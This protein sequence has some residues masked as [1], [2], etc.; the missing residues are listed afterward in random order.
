MDYYLDVK[1]Y[2]K[3]GTT[4]K[5][6]RKYASN[7]P[8]TDEKWTMNAIAEPR[9]HSKAALWSGRVLSGLVILFLTLDAAMKMAFVSQVEEASAQLG[10]PGDATITLGWLL[11]VCTLLYAFPRTAFVGAVLLTGYLGGAVAA[12]VR[13]ENPLFTHVLFGVYVGAMMWGGLYLR[14]EK[15]RAF[16]S[17]RR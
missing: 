9:T 7:L 8:T 3:V 1:I 13:I 6:A 10:W 12:H 14:D 2:E 15:L 5:Y 16:L 17:W 11:L 4:L